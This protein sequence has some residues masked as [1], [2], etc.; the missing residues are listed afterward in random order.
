MTRYTITFEV[1]VDADT[2]DAAVE[3]AKREIGQDRHEPSDIDYEED[4]EDED[5]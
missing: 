5:E 4:E 3:R 2:E 1:E